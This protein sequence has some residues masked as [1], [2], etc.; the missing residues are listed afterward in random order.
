MALFNMNSLSPSS[1]KYNASVSFATYDTT[2]TISSIPGLKGLLE[3]SWK[4][5]RLGS[6]GDRVG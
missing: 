2:Y 1:G 4:K 3:R 5:A 6:M